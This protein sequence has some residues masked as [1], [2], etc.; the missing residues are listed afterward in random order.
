MSA[1]PANHKP[2][3]TVPLHVR[4]DVIGGALMVALAALVWFGTVGL[5]VGPMINFGP[6]AMPRVLAC[7]LFIGGGAILLRGVLAR[8]DESEWISVAVRPPLILGIAIILFALFIRGG[9]FWLL[10]TPRVGLMIM[11]PFTVFVAGFATPEAD[12]RELLVLAFALTAAVLLVF[13][14]LLGV[15]IPV[16]PAIVQSA[17]PSSFGVEAG[18]RVVYLLQAAVAA[19]FY[20]FFFRRSAGSRD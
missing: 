5:K 8:D 13:V 11:G 17:I 6:G 15:P 4:V 7:I 16:F 19:A 10:T 2:A 1:E 3:M 18:V 20:T 14:D 9:E 12:W